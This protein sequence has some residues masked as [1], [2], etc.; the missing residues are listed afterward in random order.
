MTV[1]PP[2]DPLSVLTADP[3]LRPLIEAG[4]PIV[5][6]PQQDIYF[7]LLRSVISQQLSTKVARVITERLCRLFPHDYPQPALVAQTPDEDLR[8]VGLSGQ[9]LSYIRN[10]VAFA[11]QGELGHGRLAEMPDEELIR[12]LTQIKGVGRWTAEMILMFALD[13]PDVL[14]VDDL[15]IQN[16]MRKHYLL[17]ETGKALAARMV[18][19]AEAWRPYRTLACKYLWQS[20]DNG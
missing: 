2:A 15:G 12:H 19:V 6:R 16:A 13:R 20:L 18:Q 9:K 4:P 8:K 5:P 1:P 10:I 7:A 14:P 11:Q 3:I 17:P